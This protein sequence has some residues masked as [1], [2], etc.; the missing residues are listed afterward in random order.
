[1]ADILPLIPL[2]A[3]QLMLM[4]DCERAA[5]WNRVYAMWSRADEA[6]HQLEFQADYTAARRD[7]DWVNA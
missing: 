3:R 5:Y 6:A 1:M 4:T 7:D 2:T